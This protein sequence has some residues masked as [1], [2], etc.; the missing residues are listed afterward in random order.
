M[1]VKSKPYTANQIMPKHISLWENDQIKIA[2]WQLWE[3]LRKNGLESYSE[4]TN[5]T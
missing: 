4:P 2:Q 3:L 5:K 1:I